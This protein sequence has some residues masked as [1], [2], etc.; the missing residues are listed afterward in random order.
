VVPKVTWCMYGDMGTVMPLGFE[1]TKWIEAEHATD[2]FDLILH[3]GDLAYAGTGS[4]REIEPI[5]DDWMNQI[6]P[7]ASLIPYQVTVGNHE[8]YYNWTSF[9][10]RF[11]MPFYD[12]ANNKFW[13]SFDYA[14]VHLVAMSMDSNPYDENSEQYEWLVNDLS[15]AY[16]RRLSSSTPSWIILSGHRPFLC[17][18]ESEYDQHC[19]GAP[20]LATIEPLLLK[21][22]VDLVLTGHMHC[23]ERTY[24]NINGTVTIPGTNNFTNIDQPIYIVQGTAGAL[25]AER[26][27]EPQPEWS[28][29][30]K[31]E[32]GYGRMEVTTTASQS[33][34]H[35]VFHGQ[36]EVVVDQVWLNKI[37]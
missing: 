32:Y 31:L 10:H 19:P 9:R 30:R 34:L 35:Y 1:V 28:A 11:A 15:A 17:S 5:W 3:V 27:I 14:N 2:P 37:K 25:I 6:Q 20:L 4:D 13:F 24:P 16:Q 18:D 21:Y 22:Q 33:T 36:N 23:Y 29:F 8:H 12:R 7:L 26:W